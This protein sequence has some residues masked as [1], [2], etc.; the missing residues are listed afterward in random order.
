MIFVGVGANLPAEGYRD[1]LATCQAALDRTA[2]YGVTIE[3]L[4]AW[5]ESAPVP[6]SDQPWY[7]NAVARVLTDLDAPALLR[8][9]HEIEAAFGRRRRFVNAARPLDL[10]L[11]DYAGRISDADDWPVLPH[12][13]LTERAFVLLPLRDICPDWRHPIDKQGLP[14]LISALPNDQE[15]RRLTTRGVSYTMPR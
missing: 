12:P 4:S 9:L 15:V 11:L 3:S 2:A 1:A 13:R 7:I 10:D 5:Y 6:V 14:E 8:S